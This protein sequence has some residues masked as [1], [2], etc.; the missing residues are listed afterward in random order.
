MNIDTF[1]QMYVT[2][3]QE[4][5]SVETQ[6][7]EALPKM[8]DT[9]RRVELKQVIRD[10]LQE[11]RSQRD[12]LEELLRR[13]KAAPHEHVDQSMEAIVREADKWAEMI[14]DTD[15]RDAGLIACAQRVEHYEIAIYGT[16]ATW[17]DHFGLHEDLFILHAILDE[18]KRADEKLTA[19][20]KLVVNREAVAAA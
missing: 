5:Y 20:A 14:E 1:R 2:E 17:A 13:H 11:T 6:L 3:L 9:A 8:L 12:R 19:I 18:E 7:T 16:L 15:L 10:H 4:L